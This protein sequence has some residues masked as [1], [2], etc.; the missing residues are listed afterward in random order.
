MYKATEYYPVDGNLSEGL[1]FMI[2]RA[3]KDALLSGGSVLVLEKPVHPK[4]KV[5]IRMASGFEGWKIENGILHYGEGKKVRMFGKSGRQRVFP[6]QSPFDGMPM[7]WST[8]LQD[9]CEHWWTGAKMD[10]L[11]QE[12][13]SDLILALPTERQI[14]VQGE[15]AVR[16][17]ERWN[18]GDD[19]VKIRNLGGKAVY[20]AL[21][22]DQQDQAFVVDMK[23]E[24]MRESFRDACDV[25]GG[26]VGLP[27]SLIFG[28]AD[29][30]FS[31]ASAA[32]IEGKRVTMPVSIN[33]VQTLYSALHI[34][35]EGRAAKKWRRISVAD[36]QNPL[37]QAKAMQVYQEMGQD[38]MIAIP[39]TGPFETS[40]M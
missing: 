26:H 13:R 10:A 38:E 33:I 21:E 6:V 3:F 25:V 24:R 16:D 23:K 22:L 32:V 7:I 37:A 5:S 27:G 31:A 4:L 11:N 8:D 2:N 36:A 9:F 1:N 39:A 29:A 40:L 17:P 14:A 15:D 30:S 28:G 19:Y 20:K 12:K 34:A 18:E 35:L